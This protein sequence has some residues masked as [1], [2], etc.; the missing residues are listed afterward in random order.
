MM[1]PCFFLFVALG[2]I[3]LIGHGIW[4]LLAMIFGGGRNRDKRA[5]FEPTVTDDRAAASRY[6]RHLWSRGRIDEQSYHE[7]TEIIAQDAKSAARESVVQRATV[8]ADH[9]DADLFDKPGRVEA[10]TAATPPRLPARPAPAVRRETPVREPESAPT[11][12]ARA[13][14]PAVAPPPAPLPAPSP[15]PAPL[16]IPAREPR[17]PLAEILVAFMA[18]RNIR[19]G[20]L[21][22]GLLILCC[23]TALVVSLWSR[24][25][26]I[27]VLR[28]VIFT[29]VTAG[30]FG[31]GL[32]VHRRWKLPTTGHAVLI[33]ST[34][35]VPLNFLAFAALSDQAETH[36]DPTLIIQIIATIAF[37]FLSWQ[38]GRVLVSSTPV[39]FSLGVMLLSL[40]P[41]GIRLLQKAP[42][43]LDLLTVSSIPAAVYVAVMAASLYRQYGRRDVDEGEPQRTFIQLGIQTF[44]CLV[45]LGL[46]VYHSGAGPRAAHLLSPL[47]A[48]VA[49][50]ALLTG[51]LMPRRLGE[52]LPGPMH[53]TASSLAL[54]AAAVMLIGVG[55]AWPNPSRLLFTILI[56]AAA[57]VVL[58]RVT[59]HGVFHAVVAGWSTLALLLTFHLLR[60]AVGWQN[61]NGG[62]LL[63]VLLSAVSGQVL[64]GVVVVWLVGAEW[65]ARK[66]VRSAALG[67]RVAAI[68]WAGVSIAL[69]TWFGFGVPEAVY[70]ATWV[71]LLYAAIAFALA[72]RLNAPIST[73]A[74]CVLFQMAVIQVAVCT[75]PRADYL[76]ATAWLAGSSA[77]M[78]AT[79]A[80]RLLR[81][82][83]R[84]VQLH[85]SPLS[86]F[87]MAAS[88]IAL[89]S[90]VVNTQV[91]TLVG[92]SWRLGWLAG[93]W[94]VLAVANVW[95]IGFAAGQL[96]MLA[97]LCVT[98]HNH[99]AR[100]EWIKGVDELWFDPRYWQIHLLVAGVVCLLWSLLRVILGPERTS[101]SE[102]DGPR[103]GRSFLSVVRR[104]LEPRF[105]PVDR[106]LTATLVILLVGLA[107]WSIWPGLFADL[108]GKVT[109]E[110][111]V[112]HAYAAG[113]GSWGLLAI[114]VVISLLTVYEGLH[115]SGLVTLLIVAACGIVLTSAGL[116]G[117]YSAPTS[118]RWL[119]SSA[120]LVGSLA[121]WTARW[122]YSQGVGRLLRRP[123]REPASV[124]LVRFL[125]LGL[126]VL[127]AIVL[128]GS[129]V[130]AINSW[131]GL[132]S[133]WSDPWIRITL[134]GPSAIIVLTLI[135]YALVEQRPRYALVSGVLA[136]A[137]A[138]MTES[139]VLARAGGGWT[140]PWIIWLVQVSAIVLAGVLVVWWVAQWLI[141]SRQED[142]AEARG[143]LAVSRG[144]LAL[145][146]MV[147]AGAILIEPGA[148]PSLTTTVGSLWGIL[149]VASV[150]LAWILLAGRGRLRSLGRS[151]ED[152][153]VLQVAM[154]VGCGLAPLDLGNWLC[155][156]ATMIGL[157]IAGV[158]RLGAG[159]WRVRL[160]VG[161]GWE[162][163]FE[164]A[165][166]EAM[167]GGSEIRHDLSCARCGYNLRGLAPSTR[168]PE[169]ALDVKDSVEAAMT[170]LTPQ[171]TSQLAATR[172]G[173]VSAV[174][175]CTILCLVFAL[176]SAFDDPQRPWWSSSVLVAMSALCVALAA[177]A[178]RRKL[179][180]LGGLLTGLGVSAFWVTHV[181]P[182]G[183]GDAANLLNL[184]NANVIAL[185]TLAVIWLWIDRWLLRTRSES[186][187]VT[188][189]PVFHRAISV[190]AVATVA[191][192]TGVSLCAALVEHPLEGVAVMCWLAWAATAVLAAL[193]RFDPDARN[194]PATFYVLGLAGV[195]RGVV[196]VGATPAT[197]VC[198]L[199]A[200]LAGYVLATMLVWRVWTQRMQRA[201][202][203]LRPL[204]W[205][206]LANCVVG[207]IAVVLAG[208]VSMTNP[209]FALRAVMTA[210]PLLCAV[211]AVLVVLVREGAALRTCVIG[212]AGAAAV[213]FAWAW[214]EPLAAGGLLLRAVNTLLTL[215]LGAMACSA[216]TVRLKADGAWARAVARYVAGSL[217]VAGVA[218][219]YILSVDALAL[220]QHQATELSRLA[221]G[222]VLGAVIAVIACLIV[223]ATHERIDPLRLSSRGKE[224]YVYAAEVIAG[225]LFVHIRASMPWLFTGA[226]IRYWPLLLV[227]L[228]F[229]SVAASEACTR[230]GQRVVGRPLGRTGLFL[231][232]LASLELFISLSRVHYSVVLL[233]MGAF[234][235]VL[236]AMRRSFVLAGLAV[237]CLNGSLWY[238]LQHTP[239]LGIAQHPQ[240]WFI[241][242]AFAV[243][244][245]GQLNRARLSPPQLRA[246]HY[247]C[248]LVVY[249]SST[250][251]VFLI[252]VAQAPWLPLILAALS[253][254][255]VFFGLA[256]RARS[257]LMLG[258][259]FLVLSL[260]TMIWH[261]A[262]DLGWTWVWYVAGIVTGVIIITIFALFERKRAEMTA[263]VEQ[264]RTWAD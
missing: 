67:Y 188:Q 110:L 66:G 112:G 252:G 82:R 125:L 3:T 141:R 181:W 12:G 26:A 81:V 187:V 21:I 20:E 197:L 194:V 71:F 184:L 133:G 215:A 241:P 220:S 64:A 102:P 250:A 63:R 135:G 239:G 217:V 9:P 258:T 14:V 214:A 205:L 41:A 91:S 39:L 243:L 238:L 97:A 24:I 244:A 161:A 79:V 47:L 19:W 129:V 53:A 145:M 150:E 28:F 76:L 10:P 55:L 165:S 203:M 132:V 94:F 221:N 100:A 178:P 179:A 111:W 56:N 5:G 171:W 191:L 251:D 106:W 142:I 16:P 62:V 54:I 122:W 116:E 4:V 38:A 101:S 151:P 240:L 136:V 43:S 207:L 223:F 259:A 89:V 123:V 115:R 255:G 22:G 232:V 162:Q 209:Q 222:A 40:A 7:L 96:A 95:P 144:A 61:E 160:L 80:L 245:A 158:C 1:E 260:F 6:L 253:I 225:L 107:S 121:L 118:S 138:I 153:W 34:L 113:A 156:H 219:G 174:L 170:R 128:T 193:C 254:V 85:V 192:L 2:L 229:A 30:L 190:L 29:A 13:E 99:F 234:Y 18:E 17:R 49:I 73:W 157:L 196:Q 57:A 109:G 167:P 126:F 198:L 230:Y 146:L 77:F 152:L 218:F 37:A 42:P 180:Y 44:A 75:W 212:L 8:E 173:T 247:G 78:L 143:A 147:G 237:L 202:I 226:I 131:P 137:L 257:F 59:R 31:I 114:L 166:A 103:E 117:R 93:I 182:S 256:T 108:G 216:L 23:S 235:G 15:V 263:W 208:Y 58:T 25:E 236:A 11:A 201:G 164:T 206:E 65:F 45:P 172:G 50:P 186:L 68:V 60:G 148:V 127:P 195:V 228:G 262:T 105:P 74:G 32:F 69:V 139:C 84:F 163:T 189:L 149:A 176:R 104:L 183:A 33:I 169:C 155:F 200:A 213:L 27:P 242:P 72:D 231:P 92:L 134:L 261:A 185:A 159:A 52:K 227:G 46:I 90:M 264:L 35:L 224:A 120:F 140:L 199:G 175:T 48:A 119:F 177:W 98:A 130:A 124:G 246:L 51:L 204:V 36:A 248:L 70:Q 88:L 211:A 210:V 233:T 83:E 86:A 168:C 249:V 87:A 154:L